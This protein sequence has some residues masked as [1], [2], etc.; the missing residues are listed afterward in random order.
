MSSTAVASAELIE[1]QNSSL[2]FQAANASA[3]MS[4]SP[5]SSSAELRVTVSRCSPA[6]RFVRRI[7]TPRA[8]NTRLPMRSARRKSTRAAIR[9]ATG[10]A[11]ERASPRAPRSVKVPAPIPMLPRYPMSGTS[12]AAAARRVAC[13]SRRSTTATTESSAITIPIGVLVSAATPAPARMAAATDANGSSTSLRRR[14]WNSVAR[15]PA[16]PPTAIDARQ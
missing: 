7:V 1:C 4:T 9:P 6:A 2:R 5:G 10:A 14:Y 3:A 8:T 15:R 13:D 11:Q 12:P 16:R